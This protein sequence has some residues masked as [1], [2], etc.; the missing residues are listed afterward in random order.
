MK[1]KTTK[2]MRNIIDTNASLKGILKI[3]NK[4]MPFNKIWK[5]NKT[6]HL[7]LEEKGQ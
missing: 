4:I 1:L 3:E 5:I 6:E 7:F 2:K